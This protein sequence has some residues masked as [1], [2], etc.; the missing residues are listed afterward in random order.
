[1]TADVFRRQLADECR[2]ALLAQYSDAISPEDAALL[3]Q[4]VGAG[5]TAEGYLYGG[6]TTAVGLR[7]VAR[8]LGRELRRSRQVLDWGCGSARTI[9]WFNDL[10]PGTALHGVDINEPAIAWCRTHC[11]VGV[12]HHTEPLPPL[13]FEDASFDL[14]YGISV[15]THLDERFQ[16]DWLDELRRIV[17]PGGLVLL[18]VHGEDTARGTLPPAQWSRFE[19]EGFLFERASGPTVEQLPDFYQVAYHS[20]R[21]IEQRWRRGFEV[22]LHLEHGPFYRQTLVAL[23]RGDGAEL[24]PPPG[25]TIELPMA[26]LDAPKVG[27]VAT[28][29][30]DI[31]LYG[32]AFG[33]RQS[34]VRIRVVVDGEI[35]AECTANQDRP[36]VAAAFPGAAHA[37]RSGFAARL[38]TSGWS[39]GLRVLWI[40]ADA[41]PVPLVATYLRVVS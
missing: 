14:V 4:V 2:Q 27:L 22:L 10:P 39:R 23:R 32:W 13:P 29:G 11:R 18:S 16:D 36:D 28:A 25:R 15:L 6:W 5:G 30:E 7:A 3:Q 31:D 17:M 26:S 40:E 12:F 9:R 35:V 8:T 37:D 33:P 21:Y 19:A 24:A 41:S 20:R 38:P 1:M 34:G